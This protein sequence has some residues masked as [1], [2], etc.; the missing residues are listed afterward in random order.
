MRWTQPDEVAEHL[1]MKIIRDST[2][3]EYSRHFWERQR[4]KGDPG[5]RD[6]LADI[7]AGGDP[8][9][10]LAQ[11]YPYKLPRHDN[12][13]IRMALL[14]RE[15]VEGLLVHDYMPCDR[16]MRDRGLVPD[17]YT[18]RLA[19]LA[20]MFISREYFHGHRGDRQHERYRT[21]V[22]RGGRSRT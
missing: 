10:W 3:E 11:M 8:V 16:W 5:D 14:D 22:A 20:G 4:A 6:A 12:D 9:A 2:L 17:P 1:P 19:D 15:D 7:A 18:R 21:W 13:V